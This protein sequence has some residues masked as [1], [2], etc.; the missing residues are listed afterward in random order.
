M[1]IGEEGIQPLFQFD[2]YRFA[3]ISLAI[4][5]PDGRCCDIDDD[6]SAEF[7]FS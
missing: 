7:S 1:I 3:S 5:R 6:G 2:T 4:N